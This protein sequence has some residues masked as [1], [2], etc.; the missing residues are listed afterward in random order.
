MA[1]LIN[2][3]PPDLSDLGNLKPFTFTIQDGEPNTHVGIWLRYEGSDD[4]ILVHNGTNFVWPFDTNSTIERPLGDDSLL[5]FSVAS[6]FGWAGN[7][8]NVRVEPVGAVVDN[9]VFPAFAVNLG[10]IMGVEPDHI[11]ADY[12]GLPL[13][14]TV[15]SLPITAELGAT[16]YG[17][18]SDRLWDGTDHTSR[19]VTEL[20]GVLDGATLASATSLLPGSDSFACLVTYRHATPSASN[21]TII[22]KRSGAD[23]KGWNI[24]ILVGTNRVFA[25]ADH[26]PVHATAIVNGDIIDG[27]W[28]TAMIVVNRTTDDLFIYTD[29]GSATASMAGYGDLDDSSA[30]FGFGRSATG[31]APSAGDFQIAYAAYWEGT[32]AEALGAAALTAFWQ[33][34]IDNPPG[35]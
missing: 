22:S 21:S 8:A 17:Q 29:F 16:L 23:L 18:A 35:P 31:S 7:I 19:I 34:Q 14:D 15:G 32:K 11:W 6:E 13:P 1:I 24:G 5:N 27:D 10:A 28:H 2:L 33:P 4:D 12:I 25:Q 20:T 26:G 9:P 30:A 3:N